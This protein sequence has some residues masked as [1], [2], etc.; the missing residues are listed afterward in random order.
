MNPLLPILLVLVALAGPA[1]A[2]AVVTRPSG[3]DLGTFL[4]YGAMAVWAAIGG[5]VSFGQK[6]A[7]G[8]ARWL[9]IAE[10]VGEMFVSGFAG[11]TTGL[12]LQAFEAP[13]P[14]TFAAVGLA[15]HAGGRAIFWLE[16]AAQRKADAALGIDTK[17]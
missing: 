9:N 6:V 5:L 1:I 17:D 8:K 16:V 7:G 13:V 3:V 11:L 12:I 14:L 10:L 15:G 2:Q 4:T